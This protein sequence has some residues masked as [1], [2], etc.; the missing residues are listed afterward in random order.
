MKHLI[1]AFII[2][3]SIFQLT[4]CSNNNS[5]IK[6]DASINNTLSPTD[7]NISLLQNTSTPTSQDTIKSLDTTLQP[8]SIPTPKP[9]LTKKSPTPFPDD[10]KGENWFA[11]KEFPNYA[12]N[13]P[14]TPKELYMY[15]L[16]QQDA[17]KNSGLAVLPVNFHYQ[18][19]TQT[20]DSL[21][22]Y[23]KDFINTYYTQDSTNIAQWSNNMRGFIDPKSPVSLINEKL[24]NDFIMDTSNKITSSNLN[25]NVKSIFTDDSLLYLDSSANYRIRGRVS[26]NVNSSI[27]PNLTIGS[28]TYDI[29]LSVK[30]KLL[31]GPDNWASKDYITCLIIKLK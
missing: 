29:E 8:A 25:I 26:I 17:N 31:A 7:Q 6:T 16:N 27:D 21:I 1:A 30:K 28:Y 23:Y 4:A 10:G 12:Y 19:P 22:K 24:P 18:T 15:S 14:E 2:I 9:Q 3:A 13:K 5:S 20:M 11:S